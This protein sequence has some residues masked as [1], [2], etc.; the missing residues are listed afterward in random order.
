MR[1]TNKQT[2]KRLSLILLL[3]LV[4]VSLTQCGKLDTTI[5]ED[6]NNTKIQEQVFQKPDV[7]KLSRVA[8]RYQFIKS[9]SQG[10]QRLQF[11]EEDEFTSNEALL[12]IEAILNNLSYETENYGD[13]AIHH[14]LS[15]DLDFYNGIINGT[16]L[17]EYVTSIEN[18]ID[19]VREHYEN[20]NH[21]EYMV[22]LADL[23]WETTQTAGI[24]TVSVNVILNS[25]II[26]LIDVPCDL[27]SRPSWS[28]GGVNNVNLDN[29]IPDTRTSG[30]PPPFAH[31]GSNVYM[32][33][34]LALTFLLNKSACNPNLAVLGTPSSDPF[35]YWTYNTNST[36]WTYNCGSTDNVHFNNSTKI[37]SNVVTPPWGAPL[38]SR[39]NVQAEYN[40][41]VAL[42]N[43][44]RP[45]G[46]SI[47]NYLV[48]EMP[49]PCRASNQTIVRR[50]HE[51]VVTYANWVY[52]STVN[53]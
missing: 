8:E 19:S 10:E 45:S 30:F 47:V 18:A 14:E 27:L 7:A 40:Y 6:L 20:T 1:P 2:N 25:V 32:R 53:Q 42:A 28:Y 29:F 38:Q 50:A 37:W 41:I 23:R 36:R 31:I 35:G 24:I 49:E 9:N 34:Y 48:Y 26:P 43:A 13:G 11:Q 4:G 46:K 52:V 3:G 5:G 22:S 51:V 16:T 21:E 39:A 12:Y 33:S 15:F 44:N 17:I